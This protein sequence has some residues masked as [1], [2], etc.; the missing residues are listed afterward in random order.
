M[1]DY[2]STK[3][4]TDILSHD[5]DGGPLAAPTTVVYGFHPSKDYV[6]EVQQRTAGILDAVDQVLYSH[7]GGPAV[8]AVLHDMPT[9]FAK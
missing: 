6:G 4:M 9:V 1:V 5:W 8:Y 7:D 3:E 2:V